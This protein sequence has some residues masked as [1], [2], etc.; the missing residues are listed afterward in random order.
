SELEEL[1]RQLKELQDKGF[2]RPSS[3]S[4]G[5]LEEHEEHLGLVLILLKEEKLYAK[6]SKCEFW[7]R[8]VQFLRHVI[9][10]DGIHVDPS[11]IEKEASKESTGL[12]RR[13]DKMIELRSDGALYYLDQK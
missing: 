9:N 3:S 7:L 8:K 6:F 11:K 10:G 2:I 4:W 13:I 1:S 12:Q 5:A